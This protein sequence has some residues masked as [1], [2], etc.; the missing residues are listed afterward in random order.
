MWVFR[1]TTALFVFWFVFLCGFVV[2]FG[3]G[4][5][6]AVDDSLVYMVVCCG[7]VVLVVDVCCFTS[8]FTGCGVWVR[9]Y[10]LDVFTQQFIFPSPLIHGEREM[11]D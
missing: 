2:W 11:V 8:L 7:S 9:V 6:F 4:G 3:F 5:D 1:V 10:V